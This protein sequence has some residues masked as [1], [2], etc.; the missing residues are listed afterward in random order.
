MRIHNAGV[1]SGSIS[2]MRI[3]SVVTPRALS[4]ARRNKL[5]MNFWGEERVFG[6]E[7][8][9]LYRPPPPLNRSWT[10]TNWFRSSFDSKTGREMVHGSS[11]SRNTLSYFLRGLFNCTLPWLNLSV[12]IVFQSS[13]C[14]LSQLRPKPRPATTISVNKHLL[15]VGHNCW[16]FPQYSIVSP[17][18]V[19]S[20]N[21]GFRKGVFGLSFTSVIIVTATPVS[22]SILMRLSLMSRVTVI[23]CVEDLNL[24]HG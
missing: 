13:L 16:L 5:H 11:P 4:T 22:T 20:L 2:C 3:T 8:S 24:V 1:G 23:G 21:E 18:Y 15:S 10:V 6:R 19:F 17:V 7:A 9:P 12:P 14:L